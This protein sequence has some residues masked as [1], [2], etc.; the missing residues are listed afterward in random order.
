MT[1]GVALL[2][3]LAMTRGSPPAPAECRDDDSS[4]AALN[5][6]ISL[7]PADAN[8]DR[9]AERWNSSLAWGT[10]T[11]E[12]EGSM[13]L[14]HLGFV[15]NDK[16]LCCD[17][18]VF[19][20]NGDSGQLETIVLVRYEDDPRGGRRRA[21]RFAR[22]LG[23]NANDVLPFVSQRKLDAN[24]LE[25]RKVDV[26]SFGKLWIVRVVVSRTAAP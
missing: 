21:L 26:E 24:I 4:I 18:F 3:F 6:V 20:M 1:S 15:V 12:P 23:E 25:L 17:T 8:P 19:D 11:R 13:S 5:A 16:C 2:L 22:S 9:V 14:S 10:R 7:Q